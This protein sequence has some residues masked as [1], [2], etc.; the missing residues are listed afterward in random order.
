LKE[1][2]S[3]SHHPFLF[4][5][6]RSDSISFHIILSKSAFKFSS[7]NFLSISNLRTPQYVLRFPLILSVT[8]V[9]PSI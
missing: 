4:P 9:C 3:N 6:I 7:Y 1:V 5:N 8:L 2:H